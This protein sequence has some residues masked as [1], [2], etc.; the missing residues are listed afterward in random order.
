M[1]PTDLIIGPNTG[2]VF[3]ILLLKTPEW[4]PT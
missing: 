1:R 4:L 3:S 2:A